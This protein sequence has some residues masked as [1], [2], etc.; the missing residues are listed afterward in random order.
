MPQ[1]W[2]VVFLFLLSLMLLGGGIKG[3]REAP[4]KWW[5]TPLPPHHLSHHQQT[6]GGHLPH[7]VETGPMQ[8]T[9]TVLT[10]TPYKGMSSYCPRL[11]PPVICLIP[12]TLQRYPTLYPSP[13]KKPAGPSLRWNLA[14][15]PVPLKACFDQLLPGLSIPFHYQSD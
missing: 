13:L 15:E 6:T 3:D 8:E 12:I 2:Y 10:Q 7:Q 4:T 14:Q 11:I 1:L 9:W 5:W